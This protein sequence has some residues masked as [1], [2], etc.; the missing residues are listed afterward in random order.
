MNANI[1]IRKNDG[2]ENTYV[3]IADLNNKT[4]PKTVIRFPCIVTS[5]SDGSIIGYGEVKID[6]NGRIY[7]RSSIR[8][9]Y[10]EVYFSIE[11]FV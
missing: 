10:S 6:T 11:W 4:F 2:F 3:A 9:N 7:V 5:T 8:E 1:G